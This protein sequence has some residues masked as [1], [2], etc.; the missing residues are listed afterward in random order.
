MEKITITDFEKLIGQDEA[1]K[2]KVMGITGEG[3]ALKDQLTALAAS[4]GYGIDFDGELEALSD[5]EMDGVA[6]GGDVRDAIEAFKNQ[7]K[8]MKY[9]HDWKLDG[10]EMTP[11]AEFYQIFKCARCGITEKRRFAQ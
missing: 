6:G 3:E 1:L 8:C 5:E 11:Y 7:L 9:G 4:L 10:S 2:A